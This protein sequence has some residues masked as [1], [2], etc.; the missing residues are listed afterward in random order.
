MTQENFSSIKTYYEELYNEQKDNSFPYDYQWTTFALDLFKKPSSSAPKSL[1]I[2]CGVGYAC[3]MLGD[4]GY[5]SH[6]IDISEVALVDARQKYPEGHF[7]LAHES[8][9]MDFAD[10]TFDVITCF[11]VLEHIVNPED[12]VAESFRTLKKDGQALYVVP[13]T[14][15]PYFLFTSG[16]GQL[17]EIPRTKKEWLTMFDKAGFKCVH[18]DKDPGPTIL[19]KFPLIKKFKLVLNKILNWGPVDITY[20]FFFILEKK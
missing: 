13:N 19:K 20:Q 9:K 17:Y 15:S 12:V 7:H 16:T 10:E 2:G 3:K 1:D 14:Y 4:R 6:G 18:I 11:G 8:G 5:E